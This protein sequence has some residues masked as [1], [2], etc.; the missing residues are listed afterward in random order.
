ME[1]E[2]IESKSSHEAISTATS[3]PEAPD[4]QL[5]CLLTDGDEDESEVDEE[6]EED[7]L[8][9]LSDDSSV[10]VV[11]VTSTIA[12]VGHEGS[13]GAAVD[14]KPG[15]SS[16]LI[17]SQQSA[18]T[19][20]LREKCPDFHAAAPA[21]CD[22]IPAQSLPAAA[23]DPCSK[24]LA[25]SRTG[26][27]V[28]DLTHSDDESGLNSRRNNSHSNS[29]PNNNH[30]HGIGHHHHHYHHNSQ[31][32][33][34][35]TAHSAAVGQVSRRRTHSH[36]PVDAAASNRMS[37]SMQDNG[38]A[39][40]PVNLSHHQRH[41]D[42]HGHHQSAVPS[43]GAPSCRFLT[44]Q[45]VHHAQAAAHFADAGSSNSHASGP[46]CSSFSNCFV[47]S[48]SGANGA[49]P[50]SCP[51]S[52]SFCPQVTSP[53][54]YFPTTGAPA[55]GPNNSTPSSSSYH[56][57]QPQPMLHTAPLPN[58]AHLFPSYYGPPPAAHSQVPYQTFQINPQPTRLHPVHHQRLLEQQRSMEMQRQAYAQHADGLRRYV[59]LLPVRCCLTLYFGPAVKRSRLQRTGCTWKRRHRSRIPEWRTC[60]VPH[61]PSHWH[62]ADWECP[63]T[64][65]FLLLCCKQE[66]HLH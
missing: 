12:T 1:A 14:S 48:A 7:S 42:N 41:G 65:L 27:L 64:I 33:P 9:D 66:H 60:S 31:H 52:H 2:L 59:I 43:A 4:L 61:W 55:A 63:D 13:S 23:P 25:A 6:I 56:L 35:R 15:T 29:Q 20:A 3:W 47:A 24:S 51:H 34:N 11:G 58:S 62:G 40:V 49:A 18:A 54:L 30:R 19:D 36:R 21:T 57:L 45:H 5:D 44:A 53:Q 16:L 37:C 39:H 26:H 17:S 32:N 28:I 38:A 46:P 50:S 8:N 22:P 10:E